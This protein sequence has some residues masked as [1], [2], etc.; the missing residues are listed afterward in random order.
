MAC[1][2]HCA[3]C[4]RQRRGSGGFLELVK[5]PGSGIG[6]E[7]ASRAV[8]E[9]EELGGFL[10]AEAGE[11]PQF[12]QGSGLWILLFEP[13]DRLVHLEESVIVGGEGEFH[14]L[15][16]HAF[17]AAAAF[18]AEFST[19]VLDQDTAHGFG[20]GAE[21]VGAILP[22]WVIAGHQTEPG[23]VDEGG[24]LQS[25]A[26]LFLGHFASGQAAQ[27][28]VDHRQQFVRGTRGIGG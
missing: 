22:A 19:G 2:L 15:E 23:F 20:G 8:G 27:F 11:E 13:G 12:H 26:V 10:L 24:G 7:S 21:E 14:L 3:V 17:A 16:V 9:V 6:P 4:R 28:I 5:E 1:G 18:Q 25:V